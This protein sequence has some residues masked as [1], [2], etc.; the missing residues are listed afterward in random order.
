MLRYQSRGLSTLCNTGKKKMEG[1]VIRPGK[2]VPY[3][4]DLNVRPAV[5]TL[6][7]ADRRMN[8]GLGSAGTAAMDSTCLCRCALRPRCDSQIM[9]KPLECMLPPT[10]P[11]AFSSRAG[12]EAGRNITSALNLVIY[13]LHFNLNFPPRS[14]G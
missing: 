11:F 4:L 5:A 10:F 7:S 9:M 12:P 8:G 3:S 14:L 6:C 2:L 13:V 1:N